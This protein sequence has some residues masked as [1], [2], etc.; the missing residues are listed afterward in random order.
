MGFWRSYATHIKG[1]PIHPFLSKAAYVDIDWHIT[2][3]DRYA[4]DIL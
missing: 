2:N 1:L 3:S 4:S